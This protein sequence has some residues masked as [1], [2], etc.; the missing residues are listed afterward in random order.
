MNLSA[1]VSFFE[2]LQILLLHLCIGELLMPL[3]L[4]IEVTPKD[5]IPLFQRQTIK[6][7][8]DYLPEQLVDVNLR[9]INL[10]IVI[11]SFERV[12]RFLAEF[13]EAVLVGVH[14]HIRNGLLAQ[15][16]IPVI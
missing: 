16:T 2:V 13:V 7:Y 4:L 12:T 5:A 14:K 15:E 8:V 10:V 6:R 3:D 11:L 1:G 9:I